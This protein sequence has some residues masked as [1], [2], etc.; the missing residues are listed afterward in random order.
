MGTLTGARTTPEA[1]D[2]Q[3]QF[4]SWVDGGVDSVAM[5]V[6]SHALELHRIDGTHVDVAIFT[7]LGDDHLDFHLNRERYFAAKAALFD[8]SIVRAG[9][10][11]PRRRA[12][13]LALRLRIDRHRGDIPSDNS[14]TW[15]S[16]RRARR[17]PGGDD[18]S[19]CRPG[20]IQPVERVGAAEAARLIGIDDDVIAA[21][22]GTVDAP[23]GR[24]ESIDEGQPFVVIVDYAHTP[25]ALHNVLE[26]AREL[27][28]GR[29]W[30][31]FGAG[32]DRD[33]LQATS[34]GSGRTPSE[35]TRS[36]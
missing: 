24:F 16:A 6:S 4:R 2:L 11:Q 20:T 23:P 15:R 1:P 8:P 18:G 7:N 3:R 21:A 10:C 33:C 36:S 34:D 17:S 25:D 27:G 12:R 29:L 13:P 32:G 9:G 30:V 14:T 19:G 35:P 28:P 22:L 31:V 26:A 5:E